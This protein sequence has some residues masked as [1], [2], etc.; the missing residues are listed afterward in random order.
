M[1]TVGETAGA[2]EGPK[3][4]S[5]YDDDFYTW[6]KEQ[7]AALKR[8]DLEAIDWENVTQEIEALARGEERSLRDLYSTIIQ[9]FLK[10]QY[11]V[12]GDLNRVVEWEHAVEEARID[13]ESLLRDSP[14]LKV[15]RHRLLRKAWNLG[16]EKAINDFMHHATLHIHDVDISRG[17]ALRLR[18]EWSRLL[19]QKNPYT[20]RRVEAQWWRPAPTRLAERPQVREPAVRSSS[21]TP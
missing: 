5:L 2:G 7:T 13:I 6:A 16:R 21:D 3:H 4:R 10:L 8:R 12:G 11:R 17:E 14:G 15:E 19:P 1:G 18:Q 20:R 9:H